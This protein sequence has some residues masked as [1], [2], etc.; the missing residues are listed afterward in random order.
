MALGL[1]AC[2]SSI[3]AFDQDGTFRVPGPEEIEEAFGSGLIDYPDYQALLEIARGEF[4]TPSD[5][6][7]LLQFPDLLA[8]YST[9]LQPVTDDTVVSSMG[10]PPL[11]GAPAWKHSLLFRQSQ[12]VADP[13][14]RRRLL[15][16]H[17]IYGNLGFHGELE[18]LYSGDQRW[19]RRGMEYAA[20]S[21]SGSGYRVVIG[22]FRERF[23]LG[24][25][26]GYHGRLLEHAADRDAAENFVYPDYGGTNGLMVSIMRPSGAITLVVDFDRNDTHAKKFAAA[27]FSFGFGRLKFQISGGHGVIDKRGS[28]QALTANLVSLFGEFSGKNLTLTGEAAASAAASSRSQ[29]AAA[30][31][32]WKRGRARVRIDGWSYGDRY[33]SYFSGGPSSRR[34]R[35]ITIEEIDLSCS[36]RYRGE[37]GVMVKTTYPLS[38]GVGMHAEAGYAGR[39]IDDDRFEAG[40]GLGRGLGKGFRAKIDCHRR[41]D[42]L[43]SNPR[44]VRRVQVEVTGYGETISGRIVIAR[45]HD[46]YDNRDDYLL[47]IGGAVKGI[48]GRM[49]VVCKLDR[50]RPDDPRNE[51]MY[52][53]VAYEADL[54]RTLET[55]AG[56]S[57]RYKREDSGGEMGTFRW[58]VRWNIH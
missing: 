48:G 29:A 6:L 43:Y 16:G 5:S 8:G 30:T 35:T 38:R 2:A 50:L 1:A 42:H 45:Q 4:V 14:G 55:Y 13:V 24:I 3:G 44:E 33:I 39:G 28:G 53:T 49:S 46:T 40:V 25:F 41:S 9:M 32:A 56:Y 19:Y 26:Y 51:Y 57:Y 34:S 23:G 31:L 11:S 21:D 54:S 47:L 17:G 7:F 12:T 52:V 18:Q 10:P 37:T 27:S 15:R 20:V 36:D 22:G 58:D